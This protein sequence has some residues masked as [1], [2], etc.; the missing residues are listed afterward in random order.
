MAAS[1]VLKNFQQE[2]RLLKNLRPNDA[3][4]RLANMWRFLWGTPETQEVILGVQNETKEIF[5]MVL[6]SSALKPKGYIQTVAVGLC[7]MKACRE[8]TEHITLL[9]NIFGL[10]SR[11]KGVSQQNVIDD[12][13]NGYVRIALE[14]VEEKLNSLVEEEEKSKAN[15]DEG[16]QGGFGEVVYKRREENQKHESDNAEKKLEQEF[17]K[18]LLEE[19]GY[20]KECFEEIIKEGPQIDL[21]AVNVETSKPL[22]IFKFTVAGD[23]QNLFKAANTLNSFIEEG[24]LGK[25]E[26]YMYI[27][28]P[29]EGKS[30]YVFD[31]YEA[32]EDQPPLKIA[33]AKFPD[34]ETL[35]DWV[36][37]S[38]RKF[39]KSDENKKTDAGYRIILHRDESTGIDING[40]VVY[41][42]DICK[43]VNFVKGESTLKINDKV[44]NR[45]KTHQSIKAVLGKGID[46]SRH[47]VFTERRYDN[48]YFY[49]TSDDITIATF[50]EW[51]DLT[52]LHRNNGAVLFLADVIAL[53]IDN[54]VRHDE[55]TGCIYD[56]LEDKLGIDKGMKEAKICSTCLKRIEANLPDN[57]K[58]LL[59]DLKMILNSLARASERDI[60][61]LETDEPEREMS[62]D[63]FY[64]ADGKTKKD[65]LGFMP[66]VKAVAAFLTHA[67]TQ[68]P[69]TMSVEGEWG[70]GKSSFML[71]L[72]DEIERINTEQGKEKCF[73]VEFDPWRHDKDEE[74]WAA[75][76]REFIRQTSNRWGFWMRVR[77]NLILK[78]KRF[79]WREGW[80]DFVKFVGLLIVWLVV[81][82][83]LITLVCKGVQLDKSGNIELPGWIGSVVII[84]GALFIAVGK[85]KDCFGSPFDMDLRKYMG[86]CDYVSKINFIEKFHK[87]FKDVVRSYAGQQRVYVFIDDLDRCRVPR[88]AELMESI[89]LMLSDNPNLVFIMGMDRE[90]VAAGLAVKHE[91]LLPYLSDWAVNGEVTDKDTVKR[92]VGIRYGY[93]FIEKFVQVPFVLPIP[94]QDRIKEMLFE[95]TGQGSSRKSESKVRNKTGWY[96]KLRSPMPSVFS[97]F[98]RVYRSVLKLFP[99]PKTILDKKKHPITKEEQIVVEK[100][101]AAVKKVFGDDENFRRIVQMVSPYLKYNPRRVKQFVNLFRLRYVTA[102]ST[103]LFELEDGK[104]LTFAQL[105][106]FVGIGL[107]WPLFIKDLERNYNLLEEL[108]DVAE[109]EKNQRRLMGG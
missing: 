50:Y 67:R 3:T 79:D 31:I 11:G 97:V 40:L 45:P 92:K 4:E 102:M 25:P 82:V 24:I 61:I 75:F 37:R 106:K 7:V 17:I 8:R 107:G 63:E 42:N 80:V 76:V 1:D 87:D 19:K 52:K 5:D 57:K 18:F 66:Y 29:A 101:D 9:A 73:I 39:P 32:F 93:S 28:C 15:G 33:S 44:I 16:K 81:T 10:V 43:Y 14:Y 56:F 71:Q 38:A 77:K 85:V 20:S 59:E 47:M 86:K 64:V 12:V 46:N 49:N 55:N 60:D 62:A 48:D 21:C 94:R 98:I 27:V 13:M 95:L 58:S 83:V 26:P 99:M 84:V 41:L 2:M 96:S 105:G 88:A 54:S 34:Y 35:I 68:P 89:N 74:L 6:Q 69:L 72:Q 51:D 22:A 104:R 90:K 78:L 109:S 36:E 23:D 108:V 30:I 103:N 100:V 53:E 91:K 70:S 65:L